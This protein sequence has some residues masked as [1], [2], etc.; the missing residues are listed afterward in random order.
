MHLRAVTLASRNGDAATAREQ[1]D[2]ARSLADDL[3]GDDL[4]RYHLT[5]GPANTRIHA[6]AAHLELGEVGEAVALGQGFSPPASVPPTRA[7]HHYIDLARAHLTAGDREAAL[8]DLQNARRIAPEQTR[9]HP[10]VR[11]TARLLVSL[12]RRANDDL[13]QLASWLGLTA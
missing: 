11:E 12:H 9:Y 8:R 4:V 5:F 3:G 7:G 13:T 1:V 6:V 10:M 2:A